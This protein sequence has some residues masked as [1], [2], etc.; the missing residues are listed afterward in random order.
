M[1]GE[2]SQADVRDV[3]GCL[4]C[5]AK[6]IPTLVQVNPNNTIPGHELI[7]FMAIF[8]CCGELFLFSLIGTASLKAKVRIHK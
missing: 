8:Q 4:E 5:H 1:S 7:H 6:S 3:T 2:I